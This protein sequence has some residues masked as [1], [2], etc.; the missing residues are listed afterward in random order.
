LLEHIRS[1]GAAGL[2]ITH[3]RLVMAAADRVLLLERGKIT[4]QGK[5]A[6]LMA[7][8]GAFARFFTAI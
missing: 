6:E 5:Y 8:N 7:E 4:A 3:N 1:I 2:I